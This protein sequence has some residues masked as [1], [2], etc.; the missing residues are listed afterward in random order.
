M[1]WVVINGLACAVV[2]NVGLSQ[3]ITLSVPF[4]RPVPGSYCS[5]RVNF[6]RS[7]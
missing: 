3:L 2:A 1:F 4:I 7:K 5:S 6:V